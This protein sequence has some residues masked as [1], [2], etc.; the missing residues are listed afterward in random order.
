MN[1]CYYTIQSVI[2]RTT[3]CCWLPF[4]H[5][6]TPLTL[7]KNYS[8]SFVKYLPTFGKIIIITYSQSSQ[9]QHRWPFTNRHGV[10]N[11]KTWI[12]SNTTLITPNIIL[13]R[14]V[15]FPKQFYGSQTGIFFVVFKGRGELQTGSTTQFDS[16]A[17]SWW[18]NNALF[19]EGIF[20]I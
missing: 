4:R 10:T 11:Q 2:K 3:V 17:Y 12:F 14:S 20:M 1:H 13:N 5:A 18:D 8:V 9:R 7:L 6:V 16:E 19:S 15:L